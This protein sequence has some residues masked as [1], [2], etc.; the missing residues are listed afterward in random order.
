M[1]RRFCAIAPFLFL[2]C[3]AAAQ[4]HNDWT[5]Y[6]NGPASK[7][8]K[9]ADTIIDGS[10][11]T[12]VTGT[13]QYTYSG[14]T[15]NTLATRKYDPSGAL[16]WASYGQNGGAPTFENNFAT[17]IALDHSGNVYVSAEGNYSSSSSAL[18]LV[19]YDV[20]GNV[21]WR[22]FDV[23]VAGHHNRPI[24]V[25]VDA[26]GNAYLGG[27]GG[28][29]TGTDFVFA[30]YSP[31][32]VKQW[33]R[34]FDRASL[35]DQ[36][37]AMKVDSSGHVYGCGASDGATGATMA[38]V[39]KYDAAGA[40]VWN[41]GI[42]FNPAV[43]YAPTCMDVGADGSVVIAGVSYP[44]DVELFVGRFSSA[45]AYQWSDTFAPSFTSAAG[46][47][48]ALGPDGRIYVTG[49]AEFN[50]EG[51]N[52]ACLAKW[53]SAGNFQYGKSFGSLGTHT[54]GN[55]ILVDKYSRVAIG[56]DLS[57][58]TS[59][60]VRPALYVFNG[61]SGTPLA[62][63]VF[64]DSTHVDHA[65]KI[66]EGADGTISLVGSVKILSGFSDFLV[67]HFVQ[68]V[69]S[70][71]DGYVTPHDT[72][73][74]PDAAHGV[75]RNDRYLA[76]PVAHLISGATHGTVMLYSDGSFLYTP[77]SGYSGPDSFTYNVSQS[78]MTGNTATVTVHVG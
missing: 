19:K 65:A 15:R 6:V 4:L 20:S 18:L 54:S 7:S 76:A 23:P 11:N 46:T 27:S 36:L 24:G 31:T 8:D 70:I 53:D 74:S 71:N 50:S 72:A 1:I 37:V 47:A 21:L 41:A 49:N 33:D 57:V 10:G 78:S 44:V 64:G 22:R 5:N 17:G 55:T 16:V 77:T 35:S 58:G 32:G 3:L 25:G 63:S 61:F 30:K 38:W 73:L 66:A 67:Q 52:R 48:I 62:A 40:A 59:S 69:V 39:V 68:A 75:L 13:V 12:Y 29:G 51:S 28:D 26:L 56:A 2:S 42:T 34:S 43:A 14:V 45:G 9:A 60:S